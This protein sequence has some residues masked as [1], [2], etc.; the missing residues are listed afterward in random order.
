[1]NA[2]NVT[3][4]DGE[5]EDFAYEWTIQPVAEDADVATLEFEDEGDPRNVGIR[6]SLGTEPGTVT[7][8]VGYT[9]G[10]EGLYQGTVEISLTVEE[11]LPA[12]LPSGI[13]TPFLA[14]YEK[15]TG[16]SISFAL[17]DINFE[18]QGTI[19]EGQQEW[20]EFWNGEGDWGAVD[21]SWSE[22][23]V[24][25]IT[26]DSEGR[27]RIWAVI[28]IGNCYY[29]QSIEID[30]MDEDR[31]GGDALDME[32]LNLSTLYSGAQSY[33]S[34]GVI[35]NN[36][37]LWE[38][39]GDE[40]EWTLERIS[41]G[42]NP[43]LNLFISDENSNSIR[44]D[45]TFP[46]GAG[47]VRYRVSYVALD[48]VFRQSCEF[49]VTVVEGL[50]EG[51]PEGIATLF[52]DSYTIRTEQQLSF[53]LDDIDFETSGAIPEGQPV[54]KDIWGGSDDDTWSED[55]VRTSIFYNEGVYYFQA[56]IGIG[57][58]FFQKDIE[59]IVKDGDHLNPNLNAHQR[60]MTAYLDGEGD[61]NLGSVSADNVTI[62]DGEWED[63]AYEWTI[64]PVAEDADV[65]TI[66]LEGEGDPRN[67]G[68][69]Y[70][71]GTKPGTVRYEVGYTGGADGLYQGTI[72]V[73]LTVAA[74]LPSGLPTGIQVPKK[75]YLDIPVG[76]SVTLDTADILPT[77]GSAPDGTRVWRE[78]WN[79]EGDWNQTE[80]NWDESERTMI[81]HAP[82]RYF[83]DAV[84]GIDNYILM[85]TILIVV[86][87][88]DG[89]LPVTVHSDQRFTTAYLDGVQSQTISYLWVEGVTLRGDEQEDFQWSFDRIEGD[90]NI[91]EIG[92]GDNGRSAYDNEADY[93]LLGG[94]GSVTY[95]VTYRALGGLYEGS[96]DITL[97]V[98]AEK[99]EG[100]PTGISL[101]KTEFEIK[102]GETVDLDLNDVELVGG[103]AQPGMAVWKEFW[104][105]EGDWG[106]VGEEWTSKTNRRN[107]FPN[108]GVYYVTVAYGIDNHILE[109]SVKIIVKDGDHLSPNLNIY[110]RF[111]TAYLDG[112]KDQ[113]LGNVSADNVTIRDGEWED[114]AYE[115][116]IR[117]VA[118]DA[119]VATISLEGEGD[120]RNIGIH[121]VLGTKPGTV[122]Y[123]VGYTGGPE[124]LYQG[125]V[126]ITLTVE[127]GLPA[128]LP[129]GISTPFL[130]KYEKHTG[131]SISFALADINFETQGTIPEG[132]KVWKEL[133]NDGGDWGSTEDSW[134]DD[135]EGVRTITFRE[136]GR[137]RAFAV[138]GIGNY[139]F[140]QS[141]EIVVMDGDHLNA[142]VYVS[143][144]YDT[145]YTGSDVQEDYIG[146]CGIEDLSVWEDE[147]YQ[148]S[149]ECISGGDNPPIEMTINDNFSDFCSFDYKILN[150]SSAELRYRM[151][152]TALDG[153]Y[154]GSC[155]FDV[156][157]VQ[158][159]PEDMPQGI[160]TPY[161]SEYRIQVGDSL[162]FKEDDIDFET[163]GTVPAGREVWRTF[164]FDEW[165]GVDSE[166]EYTYTFNKSGRCF[167][168]VVIGV[169]NVYTTQFIQI[170]VLD[171]DH[172]NAELGQDIRF[173]TL[174]A[175]ADE[176]EGFLG[177]AWVNSNIWDQIDDFHWDLTKVSGD[178]VLDVYL[179]AQGLYNCAF[180]Y[181]LTGGA[182]TARYRLSYTAMDGLYQDA[183]EFDLTVAEGLPEGMPEGIKTPFQ[184]QYTIHT[185]DSLSFA[186]SDIGFETPGTIPEGQDV[187]K[188]LRNDAG[189]WDSVDEDWDE[190][191]NVRTD[192]FNEEGRFRVWAVIGIGNYY[193]R[194]PI[195]ITVKD[196]DYI[197]VDIDMQGLN[198]STLYSGA[199]SYHSFGDVSADADYREGEEDQYEWTLERISAG[200]NPPLNLFISNSNTEMA[201]FDYT[202]P[203]GAGTV[204]Y[205]LTYTAVGGLYRGS[206][207]FEVN[208]VEGLPEGLP[209]G[210]STPFKDSYELRTGERLSLS[211]NDINFVTS[212]ALPD[213]ESVW[214]DLWGGSDYDEWSEDGV[215][216]LA[217]DHEGNYEI[218]AAIG[219]GNYFFSQDIAIIVDDDTQHDAGLSVDQKFPTAYLD[220]EKDQ[221]LARVNAQNVVVPDGE[222][223]DF[224]YKWTIRRLSGDES[225]ATLDL[226]S[227]GTPWYVTIHY[228]LGT[229]PGSVTY[230]VG[231]T[232]ADGLYQG[233]TEI[234]LIV[235]ASSGIALPDEIAVTGLS[236]PVLLNADDTLAIN[237]EDIHPVGE[238]QPPEGA[239]IFR[240]IWEAEGDWGSVDGRSSD[241]LTIRNKFYEPG[242][243]FFDAVYGVAN[244]VVR[245]RYEVRVTKDGSLLRGA[246][247]DQIY[248]NLYS[249]V[250]T[251]G[252]FGYVHLDGITLSEDESSEWTVEQINYTEQAPF[253]INVGFSN[254]EMAVLICTPN[255]AGGATGDATFRIHYTGG[256]YDWSRD[257]TVHILDGLPAVVPTGIN[258]L[259]KGGKAVTVGEA[260]A[261]DS[262]LISFADVEGQPT[263]SNVWKRYSSYRGNF[264]AIQWEE[265]GGVPYVTFTEP[266]TYTYIAQAGIGNLL[267]EDFFSFE[268]TE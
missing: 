73:A 214:R 196:G 212:G 51:L 46:G 60:F 39:Q 1:M 250:T 76:G 17:A 264:E 240:D 91:A 150:D 238:Y 172:I 153:L 139:Y 2:D 249:G 81:F 7:Y 145:I 257:F 131:E 75:E 123:E 144:V 213:G 137:F 135:G 236:N 97:N 221:R 138:I 90:E 33:R 218:T 62:R 58:Y 94:T 68:I 251:E 8:E 31:L 77:G 266:G 10:P 96:C 255:S 194:Q 42:D 80:E 66:S 149:L 23:G 195:E 128:N 176:T 147:E 121:Y 226:D 216:T 239:D 182:G 93:N 29:K 259:Y 70:V 166:S 50:P 233:T 57:N 6:Y 14:K 65:A 54:W 101:P 108:E 48:G 72:E 260:Q 69:H 178:D 235:E 200:D 106:S 45:Y 12:N 148:W 217:F 41:A 107:T 171:G 232:G 208:V 205:R 53:S 16:E 32:G 243:Y 28:G 174:Y 20:R 237:L 114:F 52:A 179:T 117:P 43:P 246:D 98:E 64:R 104:N 231:Y 40:Y 230:E 103:S 225:T 115:W 265:I 168:E 253:K 134:S 180:D 220:G 55:G 192:T 146:V 130:A 262:S 209:Q 89:H 198:F 224:D 261:L 227:E 124:G 79:A 267:W 9:G 143:L 78:Y 254:Q 116:T 219:I 47:T 151:T 190:N 163:A 222:E 36:A 84:Y 207:E 27:F 83:M 228:Q 102:T 136:E 202:F 129:S 30:V 85:E 268:V 11:G 59:I 118:E 162:T 63:F 164:F 187:W 211:L 5:W 22:D 24:R 119:D 105:S 38:D 34:L 21:E 15:H 242:R 126:E 19:P 206:C 229:Q 223:E 191:G 157:V 245:K 4:R 88:E 112:E 86:G 234:S 111:T 186:R 35:S 193:F 92:P 140:R 256:A 132:Q 26:F 82:G 25:T 175:G 87:E 109:L 248:D 100:L 155:E 263:G 183:F 169:G 203:G 122:R 185:G 167:L 201:W 44:L 258:Y 133:W 125:T 18:T 67:I 37:D 189:D 152:Y 71:L 3:I 188:E 61:Q 113:H 173:N 99:P 241:A 56:V 247:L 204:R 165:E 142:D 181:R 215:R 252:I 244:C 156:T 120:P 74:D 199:S 160:S 184:S 110:Q 95:R 49:D 161:P 158:G 141:I 154:Q 13:S 177:G 127:E 197:D 210:I 170:Y 159:L